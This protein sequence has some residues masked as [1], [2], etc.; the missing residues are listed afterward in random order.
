MVTLKH[1]Y[2]AIIL[3]LLIF[4]MGEAKDIKPNIVVIN[5]DDMGWMDLAIMGSKY[6]E[7]PNI[8]AL[9][10]SGARFTN[11]YAA[12]S[13]CAPSRAS[14]MTG[15]WTPRHGIYTVG[16]SERGKTSD[17]KLIPIKNT[18]TLTDNLSIWPEILHN[19]GYITCA[20]GKWHITNDPTKRGF[21][22]NI[23]GTH[24]GHPKSYYA[25]FKNVPLNAPDSTYLTDLVMAKS[26][27]FIK[28]ANPPFLLY[29]SPFAVHTPI[30]GVKD[31]EEKYVKKTGWQGQ[32]NPAYASMVE[33]LDR[34]IG[35]LVSALKA[36]NHFNN[37]LIIFTSDNGGLYGIT[38]QLPLRGGKGTY[39]EGGI[40]VPF[41][42]VWPGKIL[43]NTIQNTP[44]TNLDIFP[45]VLAAAGIDLKGLEYDGIN[46]LPLLSKNKKI[47]SRP[48]YWHFPIY[49]EAYYP[50]NNQNRDP[51]FR[52]RPGSVII[53]GDWKLHYYD[54][55]QGI[56]LYNLKT[57]IGETNNLAISNPKK[58]KELLDMLNGWKA[59]VKAPIPTK[60]NPNFSI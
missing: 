21:D 47:N 25:P 56:E 60:L 54:E 33:N 32:D 23:G 46:L 12:S 27:D 37:T 10:K 14:L 2:L 19:N 1:N 13:N 41:A 55:D 52:T 24:A 38:K 50:N 40:R 45:T 59:K 44:I 15:K 28:S 34:N 26:I 11:G 43:P 51:L 31:L 9:F 57:D 16:T 3:C 5:V 49:L 7:T 22:V 17:R 58:A 4:K 35:L 8:D 20:A 48:L 42:F 30:Q 6:Y 36:H 53:F 18:E 29:Y 39:Y